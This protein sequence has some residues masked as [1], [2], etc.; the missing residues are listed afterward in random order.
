MPGLR[1]EMLAD[2]MRFHDPGR[3][4]GPQ[5]QALVDGKPIELPAFQLVPWFARAKQ[6]GLEPFDQV[7]LD[8]DDTVTLVG[9]QPPVPPMFD[10]WDVEP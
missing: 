10:E 4:L 5:A 6:L 8:P 2:E 3:P 1:S 7:R 9:L